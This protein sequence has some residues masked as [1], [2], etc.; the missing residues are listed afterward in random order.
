MWKIE[1]GV[2]PVVGV[3]LMLVVTIIIAA[4]VTAFAGGM[5]QTSDKAPQATITGKFSQTN[6]LQITH[7]GGDE[8]VTKDI[9]I[10]LRPTNDFVKGIGALSPIMVNESY[11]Q[12]NQGTYW[13]NASGT[14]G[15]MVFRPGDSAYV[16]GN[17]LNLDAIS[18]WPPYYSTTDYMNSTST[19]W[20]KVQSDLGNQINIGKSITLEVYTIKG[21][22]ISKS[23]IVIQS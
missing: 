6:G 15:V 23:N 4:I 20:E 10:F 7:A 11:I 14:M 1:S 5:T 8:L 9:Q 16:E 18:T 21:K 13:L 12:N 17:D 19:Y 2:S 3:M 22:M